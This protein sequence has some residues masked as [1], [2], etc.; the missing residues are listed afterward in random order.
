MLTKD[1]AE[2]RVQKALGAAL[3]DERVAFLFKAMAHRK[4]DGPPFHMRVVRARDTVTMKVGSAVLPTQFDHASI[5]FSW[6]DQLN[7]ED[8]IVIKA[9]HFLETQSNPY[10][11]KT[12]AELIEAITSS[13][14]MY[15]ADCL[16]E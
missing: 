11:F 3:D 16:L 6:S 8:G 2:A 1:A 15:L 7:A 4:K 12:N 10:R 9:V 13:L 5:A 14:K